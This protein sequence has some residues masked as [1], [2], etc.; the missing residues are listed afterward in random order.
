[1]GDTLVKG[2]LL[3]L[4]TGG[5]CLGACAPVLLPYFVSHPW[6]GARPLLRRS[7]EFLAGRLFAY[8]LL[9]L[10]MLALGPRLQSSP[11]A[12][13]VAAVVML[14]LAAL[15]VLYG[16]SRSF[17]EWKLCRRFA[18]SGALRR[19]PFLAG[20]ALGAN[21]CP[22]L[23]LA[24]TYLLTVRAWGAGLAFAAAFF[25][26]TA[27]YLLPVFCSGC[28]S[29]VPALRGAAEIAALFSGAWFLANALALWRG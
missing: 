1:M 17:P 19:F 9:A 11:A 15:L 27:V 28:L 23:L 10:V 18:R 20:M 24:V 8:L 14:L 6:E 29:R 22:P 4:S 25:F 5:F 13:K 12:T 7:A 2:L 16:L 3:G 21:V 26:G